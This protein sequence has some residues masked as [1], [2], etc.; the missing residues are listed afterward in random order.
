M[1]KFIHFFF[2]LIHKFPTFFADHYVRFHFIQFLKLYHN[3]HRDHQAPFLCRQ[4]MAALLSLAGTAAP[5]VRHRFQQLSVIDFF[6]RELSLEFEASKPGGG[7]L[8]AA[9]GGSAADLLSAGRTASL[10]KLQASTA[11]KKKGSP[12]GSAREGSPALA[13]INHKRTRSQS[14]IPLLPLSSRKEEPT[15]PWTTP[16]PSVPKLRLPGSAPR[17][18]DSAQHTPS[19]E[20]PQRGAA[21]LHQQQSAAAA[22]S[23]RRGSPRGTS[24]LGREA[25][26]VAVQREQQQQYAA[27]TDAGSTIGVQRPSLMIPPLALLNPRGFSSPPGA[28]ASPS[29]SPQSS[30][31]PP[32]ASL[33]LSSSSGDDDDDVYED[34]ISTVTSI[35]V[36]PLQLQRRQSPTSSGVAAGGGGAGGGGQSSRALDRSISAAI[37]LDKGWMPSAR[38]AA[39]AAAAGGGGGGE[40]SGGAAV[41]QKKV[42]ISEETSVVLPSGFVFTGDLDEDVERLEALERVRFFTHNYSFSFFTFI[43]FFFIFP[44]IQEGEEDSDDYST[45]SSDDEAQSAPPS[46]SPPRRPSFNLGLNLTGV[47]APPHQ[48]PAVLLEDEESSGDESEDSTTNRRRPVLP[49]AVP[50]LRVPLPN[51]NTTSATFGSNG[52]GGGDDTQLPDSPPPRPIP[53]PV[54]LLAITASMH[55]TLEARMASAELQVAVEA[56]RFRRKAGRSFFGDLE[57]SALGKGKMQAATLARRSTLHRPSATEGLSLGGY[58]T[59]GSAT[60]GSGIFTNAPGSIVGGGNGGGGGGYDSLISYAEEHSRRLV[61]RD[62]ELHLQILVL[63]FTLIMDPR[64]Q[65]DPAYCDQYPWERKLQNI[66]FILHH[67]LNHPENRDL[68]PRLLPAL[69]ALGSP[70]M[71]LLRTLCAAFFR[72]EWYSRRARISGVAGAYATVYRCALPSWAGESTVVLKL[73]DTPKH[74]QDRC[75]QVDFHSEVTILDILAGRPASCQ[76]FDFGLDPRADALLLVLKDYRCSLKQWRAAQP[77]D[78]AAQ[79]RLYYSVYREV[80]VAVG[81]LLDSGV[82]HFDLKCDNILLEPLPGRSEAEFWAPPSSTPP[83]RVVLADFG[84]SKLADRR[85]GGGGGGG[86]GDASSITASATAVAA[87]AA[88]AAAAAAGATTSRARGTDAFKS[89]EML[90]VGGAVQK[91]HR[92]YDRRRRQGAGAASDV[93]SLGCLLFELVTGRLLFSD[94]DWLQLVARVTST[95]MQLIT[96]ERATAVAELPGVLD[97]LQYILVRDP[98][99]RPTLKDTLAKLDTALALYGHS[100]PQHRPGAAPPAHL[101]E[102]HAAAAAAAALPLTGYRGIAAEEPLPLLSALPLSPGLLVGPAT[103]VS[104]SSLREAA[105]GHVLLISH[106]HHHHHHRLSSGHTGVVSAADILADEVLSECLEAAAG[107]GASCEVI[108]GPV[109]DGVDAGELLRWV[110][111]TLPRVLLL[112]PHHQHHHQQQQQQRSVLLAAQSGREG[113]AVL[114]AVVHAMRAEGCTA[115]RAMVRASHWGLDLHLTGVHFEALRLLGERERNTV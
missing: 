16:S 58:S 71:R 65:L 96:D 46:P 102:A 67:H 69:H 48:P 38:T 29:P 88:A 79:L 76:M 78:P 22:A 27:A 85:W 61:Y 63:V 18:G 68:L 100:M 6:V 13:Q 14:G 106:H 74:I 2:K 107:V 89:P 70:A 17:S 39:A 8:G 84:E 101:M 60:D 49:R 113:A 94:T 52:G 77:E 55:S 50:R 43:H 24:R 4:H 109:E 33:M 28:D 41:S 3:P 44:Y 56:E 62:P 32:V 35:Q 40:S 25:A 72:P 9:D 36:P 45:S 7:R 5:H 91:G 42:S 98:A 30:G 87:S 54:P 57:R 104:R 26:A 111:S 15:S 108:C 19:T 75:A 47:A 99:L 23:S 1:H 31:A 95:N 51:S 66:P 64:G 53:P 80:V 115:Y 12:A 82:I 92:A 11:F 21:T 37:S 110:E 90:L 59:P 93:W 20:N 83:F 34:R 10:G 114:L 97:L 112:P 81:Q 73:L 86:G 103:S 105:V